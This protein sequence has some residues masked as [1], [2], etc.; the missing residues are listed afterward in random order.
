MLLKLLSELPPSINSIDKAL[1]QIKTKEIQSFL[2]QNGLEEF[3]A[4]VKELND[5]AVNQISNKINLEL[6]AKKLSINQRFKR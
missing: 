4:D 2:D 5:E 6:A 1:R 3:T